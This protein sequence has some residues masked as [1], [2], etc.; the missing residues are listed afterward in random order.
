MADDKPSL[1]KLLRGEEELR[2][3][4]ERSLSNRGFDYWVNRPYISANLKRDLSKVNVLIVPIE[5]YG[6]LKYPVFPI[7]AVELLEY[8]KNNA[9]QDVTIDIGCSN[10]DYREI[11]I[12]YDII[13]LATVVVKYAIWPI[14]IG[15]V[16][17]YIYD[18]LGIKTENAHLKSELYIEKEE[19]VIKLKY[20]G[21]ASIFESTVR[22]LL[23]KD[24]EG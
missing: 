21:P 17:R 1:I 12:H 6:D 7:Q 3:N 20:D 10:K 2:V 19:E 4:V 18:R 22:G 9:P 13:E 11:A 5:N 8:I 24:R 16:S 23:E 14:L 15:L